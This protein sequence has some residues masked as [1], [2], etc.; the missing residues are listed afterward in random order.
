MATN[1]PYLASYKNVRLLFEKIKQAKI[2]DAF[3]QQYLYQTLGLK[4]K[5][6]RGLIPLLRTLG[7]IDAAG[8]PSSDYAALKNPLRAKIVL[9]D[10]VRRAYG[11]LYE[12]N[13]GAH[14][15]PSEG[16]RGLIAQVAGSDSDMTNKIA[17][18]F[19]A[20]VGLGDFDGTQP[21]EKDSE[22]EREERGAEEEANGTRAP[23]LRPEFH[24]NIQVHLPSNATEETYLSI[25]NALRK[26]FQ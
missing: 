3:N 22:E 17:G 5:S 1:L 19:N 24:Y 16:L 25:F 8:R 11:P 2:P 20:L 12:A 7:F 26:A 6:D 4:S 21:E 14:K 13:E 10:A 23:A 15:L 9:A 18:T